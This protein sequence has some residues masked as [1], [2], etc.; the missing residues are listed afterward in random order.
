MRVRLLKITPEVLLTW[1]IED[2]ANLVTC[3]EGVPPDAKVVRAFVSQD[4]RYFGL[5]IESE[6][7]TDVPD[8]HEIAQL[9]VSWSVN[10]CVAL[11]PEQLAELQKVTDTPE[12]AEPEPNPREA[13]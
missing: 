12:P 2:S 8:G 13:T 4:G 7:F 6:Q 9:R 5:L 11:G 3:V 1:C 10:P